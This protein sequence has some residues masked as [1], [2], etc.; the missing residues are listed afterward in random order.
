MRIGYTPHNYFNRE[1]D[2]HRLDFGVA[3]NPID[4]INANIILLVTSRMVSKVSH[5]IPMSSDNYETIINPEL[6]TK[7][8]WVCLK[9]G[10]F[11]MK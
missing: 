2:E 7:T 11:P 1:N 10:I 8:I 6:F 5:K 4:Q 9:I 3:D